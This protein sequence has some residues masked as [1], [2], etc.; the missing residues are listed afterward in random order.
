MQ[1]VLVYHHENAVI[2]AIAG[3]SDT[4]LFTAQM[5]WFIYILIMQCHDATIYVYGGRKHPECHM[6]KCVSLFF[7]V[8]LIVVLSLNWALNFVIVLNNAGVV[9]LL[10][11]VA[12]AECLV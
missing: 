12:P 1:L 3:Y 9:V 4:S 5:S 8:L 7:V 11:S 10:R 2:H 6:F